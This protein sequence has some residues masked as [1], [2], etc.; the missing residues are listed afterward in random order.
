MCENATKNLW[1][2]MIIIRIKINS[3][4]ILLKNI[5][6]SP[7]ERYFTPLFLVSRM[8]LPFIKISECVYVCELHCSVPLKCVLFFRLNSAKRLS[9]A[10]LCD[11]LVCAYWEDSAPTSPVGPGQVGRKPCRPWW[12]SGS[13]RLAAGLACWRPRQG[14]RASAGTEHCSL[15]SADTRALKLGLARPCPWVF[16]RDRLERLVEDLVL[17]EESVISLTALL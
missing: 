14:R 13:M 9:S 2:C 6:I 1:L 8:E 17:K 15:R 7:T 12:Q 10:R 4:L 16:S 3:I 11:R 5:H